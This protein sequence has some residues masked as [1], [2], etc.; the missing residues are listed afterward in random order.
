MDFLRNEG[1]NVGQGYLISRPQ[2]LDE[3]TDWLNKRA[4]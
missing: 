3:L 4:A 1:C 2:P